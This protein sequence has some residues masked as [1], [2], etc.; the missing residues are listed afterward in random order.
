M[1]C[2]YEARRK[3]L[4]VASTPHSSDHIPHIMVPCNPAVI[5]ASNKTDGGCVFIKLLFI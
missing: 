5:T 4:E 2:M 1:E 3:L